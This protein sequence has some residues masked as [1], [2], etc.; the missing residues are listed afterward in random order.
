VSETIKPDEEKRDD[1]E[2]SL[3]MAAKLSRAADELKEALSID[4]TS[5]R[6]LAPQTHSKAR[7]YF[8]F[9]ALDEVQKAVIEVFQTQELV[10]GETPDPDAALTRIV[11][12]SAGDGIALCQRKLMETLTDLIGFET[13][14]EDAYFRD[15]LLHAQLAQQLAAQSD[16][17][18]F[19]G[20][21]SLNLAHQ[22]DGLATEIEA[23]EGSDLDPSRAW[24]RWRLAPFELSKL[25]PGRVLASFSRRF[26]LA[27][28]LAT[29]AERA[30]LGFTYAQGFGRTSAN[31]HARPGGLELGADMPSV[32]S[33]I[34]AT[35][36]IALSVLTRCQETVGILPS[37]VNAWFSDLV[38][39]NEGPGLV[40][41]E[42]LH[43]SAAVGDIVMAYDR[44][45]QVLEIA[46]GSIG[47]R[48]YRVR[49][50]SRPPLPE[51]PED[52]HIAQHV[53]VVLDPERTRAMVE[54]QAGT[55]SDRGTEKL[56]ALPDPALM[57]AIGKSIAAGEQ[58]GANMSEAILAAAKE[59]RSANEINDK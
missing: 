50:L 31:I 2:V 16:L 30:S 10:G 1:S 41:Q 39:N 23:L 8:V 5:F 15:C 54:G 11:A 14:P 6:I 38:A 35:I 20:A 4:E 19:Y 29:D 55:D 44:L 26:D 25:A 59:R 33:D 28:T 3:V 46:E 22:I 13:T 51:I 12:E 45:A 27:L 48:S 17:L 42:Q 40:Q 47:Y 43:G 57:S 37:G 21:E 53:K 56:L 9:E 34:K 52:W 7:D 18:H 36:V 32:N 58:A 49:Y 24:H